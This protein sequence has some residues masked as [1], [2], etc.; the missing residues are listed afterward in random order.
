MGTPLPE[1][2]AYR[3][4]IWEAARHALLLGRDVLAIIQDQSTVHF[5]QHG[6]RRSTAA[7]EITTEE[8]VA[9]MDASIAEARRTWEQLRNVR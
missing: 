3:E 9:E 6:G 4:D 2:L 1:L 7:S 8:L 5:M